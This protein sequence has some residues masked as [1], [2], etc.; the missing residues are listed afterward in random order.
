MARQLAIYERGCEQIV[1]V[2]S[3]CLSESAELPAGPRLELNLFRGI[4]Y[5]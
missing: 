4:D 3:L 2:S 5:V 1:S